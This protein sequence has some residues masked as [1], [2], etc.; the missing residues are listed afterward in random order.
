MLDP[1]L[2][3][4]IAVAVAEVDPAQIEITRRL[5]PAQRFALAISM[6]QIAEEVATYRLC[7]RQPHLSYHE[8]R[9]LIRREELGNE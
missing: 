7:R 2:K 1:A 5:T 6:I 4:L 9:Q 3:R 8:A